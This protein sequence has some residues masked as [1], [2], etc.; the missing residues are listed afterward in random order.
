[1]EQKLIQLT[2]L[3]KKESFNGVPDGPSLFRFVNIATPAATNKTS[4]V[5]TKDALGKSV[6]QNV[7]SEVG[8]QPWTGYVYYAENASKLTKTVAKSGGPVAIGFLIKDFYT[9]YQMYSGRELAKAWGANLIPVGLGIGGGF[10]GGLAAG[11][12]GSFAVGVTGATLGDR[13]KD[14]IKFNLKKDVDK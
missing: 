2:L 13:V 1:M 14:E 5:W 4:F 11:P 7:L 9:D 3:G 8:N 10:V 6:A 12:A